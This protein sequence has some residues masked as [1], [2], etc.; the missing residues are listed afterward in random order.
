[1][2]ITPVHLETMH[3]VTSHLAYMQPFTLLQCTKYIA[4]MQLVTVQ[5]AAMHI[6]QYPKWTLYY[7]NST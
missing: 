5:L 1:M 2:H 3:I 6:A 4:A 7:V